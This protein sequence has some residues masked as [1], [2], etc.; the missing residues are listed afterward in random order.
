MKR[1]QTKSKETF[2]QKLRIGGR[3]EERKMAKRNDCLFTRSVAREP[4]LEPTY[5]FMQD[6]E[7]DQHWLPEA[8]P[9][10]QPFTNYRYIAISTKPGQSQSSFC[11]DMAI[12]GIGREVHRYVPT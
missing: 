10:P 12:G 2:E 4:E 5:R 1:H 7:G 8:A 3:D 11:T 9:H 6:S